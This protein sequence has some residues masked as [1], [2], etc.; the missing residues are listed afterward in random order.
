MRHHAIR[1]RWCSL[2]LCNQESSYILT[3]L[4][5][6][7]LLYYQMILCTPL[8][9]LFSA[10]AT[11]SHQWYLFC[12]WIHCLRYWWW[13]L[14]S[15]AHHQQPL[16]RLALVPKTFFLHRLPSP[17]NVAHWEFGW[18]ESEWHP[19]RL[20]HYVRPAL[21]QGHICIWQTTN[22]LKYR[23]R[24]NYSKSL[25]GFISR[26]TPSHR[27][28]LGHS[29]SQTP[30]I[31]FRFRLPIVLIKHTATCGLISWL[32]SCGNAFEDNFCICNKR[33]KC[34]V[35]L[36]FYNVLY[37]CNFVIKNFCTL[38]KWTRNEDLS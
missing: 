27:L 8:L 37:W 36:K 3:S 17:S 1:W 10:T 28:N 32:L 35:S 21:V 33:W 38:N 19:R 2:F 6:F 30:P 11:V 34:I 5:S 25:N 18:F 26:T 24:S 9:Q 12:W 20:L 13:M 29:I 22:W 16:M 4:N 23:V 31:F 7:A 14:Q 15:Y